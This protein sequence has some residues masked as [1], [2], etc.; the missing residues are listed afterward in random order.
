MS[1]NMY[2]TQMQ[3]FLKLKSR[4]YVYWVQLARCEVSR[5][6]LDITG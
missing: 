2:I 3:G 5:P 1:V 6:N 4:N